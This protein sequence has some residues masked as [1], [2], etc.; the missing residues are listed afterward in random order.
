MGIVLKVVRVNLPPPLFHRN[1][2]WYEFISWYENM[3]FVMDMS[4]LKIF[5]FKNK[6]CDFFNF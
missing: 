2:K 4:Y 3:I 6:Y 1:Y 5:W